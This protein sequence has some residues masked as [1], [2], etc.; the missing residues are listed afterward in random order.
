M[1]SRP[2][3]PARMRLLLL[4]LLGFLSIVIGHGV[5]DENDDLAE[6]VLDVISLNE[7]K[8][9]IKTVDKRA[10][11]A[12]KKHHNRPDSKR[13]TNKINRKQGKKLS[14]KRRNKKKKESKKKRKNSQRSELNKK[15]R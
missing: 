2:G 5:E 12:G 9:Y 8:E 1:G 11:E 7:N 14:K 10:A 13:R 15:K 3:P 4:A 6:V